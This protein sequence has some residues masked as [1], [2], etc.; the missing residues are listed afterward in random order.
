MIDPAVFDALPDALLV[1]RDDR[2]EW[3]SAATYRMLG[4]PDGSLLGRSF[5]ALLVP[6]D[7]ERLSVLEQQRAAGWRLPETCRVQFVRDDG[8]LVR[9]DLR[10]DQSHDR[11]APEGAPALVLAA[12]DVTESER[13]ESLMARL[14]EL[15]SLQ[16]VMLDEQAL[17]DAAEPI[18]QALG[19]R[20]AF[21]EILEEGSITRRVLAAP[22]GDP[23]G[24]Y[25]RTL[26]G[27]LVPLDR[28]PILAEV[29]R[30][31]HA[32][33]LDNVPA[34]LSGPP[35]EATALSESMERARLGRSVWCPVRAG[36]KVTHLLALSGR[37]LTD[38]DFVA[39]QLL[40]AQIGLAIQT[41]RLRAELVR[42]E[43][44][45]AVG[46]MAAVL[47]HEVR[48]PIGIIF[49]ALGSLR[50][51]CG[52]R[53][54]PALLL[55]IVAEEADRLRRLVGDLLEFARPPVADRIALELRPVILQSVEAARQD[56]ARPE[57]SV[58][59]HVDVP[60]DLPLVDGDAALLRRA[61]VN[62]VVNALQHVPAG[63]RVTV[64]AESLARLVR[65][66][67]HNDGLPI[68]ADVATRV[69]EPFFTTR[70]TGTGLG[71]A[72]V[73]RIIEDLGGRVLLDNAG[74][75]VTFAIEL[76]VHDGEAKAG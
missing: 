7:R 38:H 23:V 62:L 19:W 47:A 65:V 70:A 34:S 74:Q 28:T 33:Y 25:G 50:R 18:F 53:E 42:R 20:G 52:A 24:D 60:A 54:E 68:P 48:N 17:L 67:V 3:A 43:R 14:A 37:D 63:G 66:R 58:P 64:S 45:A 22:P 30:H 76:P 29:K 27:H 9:A 75:G 1:V 46:E 39:L 40:A 26:V 73:R 8:A 44:L 5:S 12:R 59:I 36:G 56:P 21:T 15:P 4:A 55:D 61:L 69:F 51:M 72:I 49:N 10:F 13:A 2:V 6:G 31:G 32:I 71:L 41:S 35:R 57:A 11:A 16:G